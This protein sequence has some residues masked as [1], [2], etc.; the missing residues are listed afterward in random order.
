MRPTRA[1]LDSAA[2]K[3]NVSSLREAAG[4]GFFCPMIKANAYGHGVDLVAPILATTRIDAVGVALTEEGAQLRRMGFRLPVLVFA[5][6]LAGDGQVCRE[7]QLTPVLT[8]FED[9]E[10][11]D[12][13]RVGR[14]HLKFNTGM[15]RLG[16]DLAQIPQLQQRL[17]TSSLKVDGT[18][19]HF[20]HGEETADTEGPTARQLALFEQMAG[21]F[22]G[23]K[24]AH[25]SATLA[26]GFA[27]RHPAIGARP[28]IS[29]YGLPYDGA[30][31]GVGLKPVLSLRTQ[32]TQVH[33]LEPGTSVSYGA[34]WT[35][36]R[37]S[38]IGVV[39]FGYADGYSRTLSNR[40]Q[41]LFRGVR[42]PVIGTVC[43]DYVLLDLTDA[44]H[45]GA[46]QVGEEVCA[47]GRQGQDEITAHEIGERAGTIAYE[48]VTRIGARV[49][50]EVI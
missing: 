29:L 30:R 13:A 27:L 6:L 24:H 42:V 32:L 14:V 17:Q 16:F 19:T 1:L 36:A 3:H 47:L 21:G 15:Q 39:P 33:I 2:L 41:M 35:A 43:M 18:C 38:T 48:V 50:R 25:K 4:H 10:E 44:V 40:G 23:V 28:G 5:P 7:L 8:R 20:T 34:R 26:T 22:S 46:P 49:T 45:A 11:A 31:V 12:R 37:R 9:L